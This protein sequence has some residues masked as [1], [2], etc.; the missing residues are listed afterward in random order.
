MRVSRVQA[1]YM[2]SRYDHLCPNPEGVRVPSTR[3]LS[4][5]VQQGDRTGPGSRVRCESVPLIPAKNL[6][7]PRQRAIGASPRAAESGAAFQQAR[8][9]RVRTAQRSCARSPRASC[10]A[11]C[12]RTRTAARATAV[13]PPALRA[14]RRGARSWGTW[15]EYTFCGRCTVRSTGTSTVYGSMT[16]G[17]STHRMPDTGL[18]TR[19]VSTVPSL[20]STSRV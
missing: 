8:S 19:S 7:H 15:N 10:A 17:K 1:L 3:I 18:Y 12:Q 4:G 11:S 14:S 9:A 20:I 5:Y 16:A 6:T 13:R 2:Q